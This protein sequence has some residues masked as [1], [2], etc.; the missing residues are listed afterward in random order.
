M[1]FWDWKEKRVQDQVVTFNGELANQVDEVE[2]V[3]K[4]PQ[5]ISPIVSSQSSPTSPSSSNFLVGA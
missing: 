1:A 5:E 4:T 2:D 3:L